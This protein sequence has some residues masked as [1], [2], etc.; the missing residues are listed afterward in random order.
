MKPNSYF[1]YLARRFWFWYWMKLMDGFAPS[2][3]DGNYQRPIG[4][5]SYNKLNQEISDRKNLFLLI[6]STCPWSHRTYILF[7]LLSLQE[8]IKII[9]LKPDF[10]KCRWIFHEKCFQSK[11]LKEVYE[12]SNI[13]FK[14]RETLPLLISYENKK[15]TI[16]SNESSEILEI[17]NCI[18]K[19]QSLI[20]TE[21]SN[22]L[23]KFINNKINNGVYKCGFARNQNAYIKASK[24]LFSALQEIENKLSEHNDMWI[25]GKELSIA[26]IYLF[27][28][29]IRWE[30]VYSKLFKCTERE[31]S[32]FK[33]IM[34]W[35]LN[36]Y[37]LNKVSETC[38]SAT[39][40][41]DY[42]KSL[43]PLNPNQI[44]PIHESLTEILKKSL[45]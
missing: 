34:K 22:D 29:L 30:L 28:T 24:E 6:G 20:I 19:R 42:Y 23:K 13:K 27:P 17:I 15:I 39:W 38:H 21:C 1:I 31:I 12:K 35:R 45:S 18:E 9:H 44:I 7:S 3:L 16:L 33:K 43:F 26:D 2:D 5:S 25:C 37:N 10:E 4:L 41:E 40:V 14:T 32:D 8:K 36:F 11:S